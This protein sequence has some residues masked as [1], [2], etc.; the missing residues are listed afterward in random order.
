[1]VALFKA[2]FLEGFSTN[3]SLFEEYYILGGI[4]WA[5]RNL[6]TGIVNHYLDKYGMNLNIN[7]I[8]SY[9]GKSD[10]MTL[11]SLG[12]NDTIS[13]SDTNQTNSET[14]DNVNYAN[15]DTGENKNPQN[16]GPACVFP[17]EYSYST[18]SNTPVLEPRNDDE[19]NPS[20]EPF[21]YAD[22][23]QN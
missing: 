3:L 18:R 2:F 15:S 7:D 10:K 16:I 17:T 21:H 20:A 4:A 1:M 8:M 6:S 11:N 19:T 13:K 9:L 14:K 23:H 12:Q 22:E 5:T